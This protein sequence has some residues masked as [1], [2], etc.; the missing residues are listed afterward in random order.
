LYAA[1]T[2]AGA[3][4]ST[5]SGHQILNRRPQHTSILTG[6]LYMRELLLG[7]PGTFY[8]LMGMPKHCFHKVLAELTVYG[9][10]RDTRYISRFEKFGIFLY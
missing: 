2:L 10:L 4:I 9:G 8:E 3:A 6:D 1:V 5:L 7:H